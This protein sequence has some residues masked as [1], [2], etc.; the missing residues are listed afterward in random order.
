MPEEMT[1]N[2]ALYAIDTHRRAGRI[3]EQEYQRRRAAIMQI[4]DGWRYGRR[5][6]WR[7]QKRL[8]AVWAS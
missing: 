3:N 4:A 2:E 8:Y 1:K 5:I 7:Q 6:S